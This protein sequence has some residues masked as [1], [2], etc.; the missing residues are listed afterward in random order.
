[1]IARRKFI[2]YLGFQHIQLPKNR[3]QRIR[4][5][6]CEQTTKADIQMDIG[7]GTRK[8]PLLILQCY[9]TAFFA[10]SASAAKACCVIYSHLCKHLSVDVDVC[11]FKAVHHFAVR[12]VHS[13]LQQR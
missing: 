13:F 9:A 3:L 1:M 2:K 12:K 7:P 8:F 10:I 5:K 11:N 4:M 6:S